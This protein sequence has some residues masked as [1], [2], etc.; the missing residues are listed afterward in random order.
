MAASRFSGLL[1]C[2]AD[3]V[4]AFLVRRPRHLDRLVH[5]RDMGAG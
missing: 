4:A 3:V 2:L 1:E 5:P